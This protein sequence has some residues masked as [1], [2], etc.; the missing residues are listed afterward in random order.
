MVSLD[1]DLGLCLKIL[2]NQN[3][4]SPSYYNLE[5]AIYIYSVFNLN[6]GLLNIEEK[7]WENGHMVNCNGHF[8][9]VCVGQRK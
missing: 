2:Q 6:S 4:Y 3:Y 1:R 8:F 5:V 9:C 7:V